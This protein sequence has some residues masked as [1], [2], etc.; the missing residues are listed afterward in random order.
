[1]SFS[2]VQHILHNNIVPSDDEMDAIRDFLVPKRAQLEQ[3]EVSRLGALLA[4]VVASRDELQELISDHEPLISPLR[5]MP[6]DVLR[7]IFLKT[8]PLAEKNGAAAG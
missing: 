6:D 7:L 5:R 2:P 8:L 1:M 3:L 4:A